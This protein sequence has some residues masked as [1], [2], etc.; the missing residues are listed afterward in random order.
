MQLGDHIG[1]AG[2]LIGLIGLAL[3][4]LFPTKRWIG[5][6]VLAFAVILC[7]LWL[8]LTLRSRK[9]E[10]G[11]AEKLP[12]P[13]NL[14]SKEPPADVPPPGTGK[15]RDLRPVGS[16]FDRE[17]A[18]AS[19][20][21]IGWQTKQ[22]KGLQIFEWSGRPLP[23]MEASAKAF[24]SLQEPF[25]INLQSVPSLSG[26]EKVANAK[27]CVKVAILASDLSNLDALRNFKYLNELFVSQ[28][29][30]NAKN[31]VDISSLSQLKGLSDL[32]LNSVRVETLKDLAGLTQ[33][34]SVDVSGSLVSDV[35]PLRS[36]SGLKRLRIANTRIGDLSSI[37]SFSR[38][39]D[40]TID[41]SQVKSFSA[42]DGLSSLHRLT[43]WGNGD[44]SASNLPDL[45]SLTS[46]WID[47]TALNL[48]G[49]RKYAGLEELYLSGAGAINALANVS[50]AE[51]IGSLP[52][53]SH[54]EMRFLSIPSISFL[55][56]N[57]ELKELYVLDLPINQ[58]DGIRKLKK[59]SKVT[60]VRVPVVEISPLLEVESLRELN[61]IGVP[62][63]A[64]IMS[65]LE[66]RGVHVTNY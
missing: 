36:S 15:A 38:L 37:S 39:E 28:V 45:P 4:F 7:V 65:A 21:E 10:T 20:T 48:H 60:L 64:D 3:T 13:I 31:F 52:K 29:P 6:V 17:L 1:V 11:H 26:F 27:G 51:E 59:L 49:L 63:R 34:R 56:G 46:M 22:E 18:F 23:D 35:D 5:W 14:P 33:L 47:A 54:L 44:F 55:Q 9:E 61:L 42:T 19:L 24:S 32:T 43:I 50:G 25:Q 30:L 53:L 66:T 58:I 16:H 8:C 62:A 41:T 12:A 40:L 57:V 2:I